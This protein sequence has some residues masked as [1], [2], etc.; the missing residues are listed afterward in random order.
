MKIVDIIVEYGTNPNNSV[1]PRLAGG[2]PQAVGNLK[3]QRLARSTGGAPAPVTPAP[4]PATTPAPATASTPASTRAPIDD[5]LDA[6][7][8]TATAPQQQTKDSFIDKLG[9]VF[10]R[11][12]DGKSYAV[13][14][15]SNNP[16]D[17]TTG[18]EL[19]KAAPE[20]P[21]AKQQKTSVTFPKFNNEPSRTYTKQGNAWVDAAGKPI[22]DPNLLQAINAQAKA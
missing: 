3:A 21:A 6:P 4:A 19:N 14:N 9:N 17:P 12:A 20:Q 1:N 13:G 18:Y 22:T 16:K 10:N 15:F 8:D 5:L 11:Y 7:D 2:V